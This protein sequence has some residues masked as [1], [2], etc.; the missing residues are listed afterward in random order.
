MGEFIGVDAA[1][2]PIMFI[3]SPEEQV[4]KYLYENDAKKISG[5]VLADFVK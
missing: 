3:I 2:M 5:S 4:I 1:D